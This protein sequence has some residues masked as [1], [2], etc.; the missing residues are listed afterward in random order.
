MFLV[1]IIND[2]TFFS[3][4]F[5]VSFIE[6][7]IIKLNEHLNGSYHGNHL[8]EGN[9]RN[10]WITIPL[11]SVIFTLQNLITCITEALSLYRK[12]ILI[13]LILVVNKTM[14]MIVS[15]RRRW[16]NISTYHSRHFFST[17]WVLFLYFIFQA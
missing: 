13:D 9:C 17:A 14:V 6:H 3:L 7:H 11:H 4:L 16:E 12:Y 1:A 15:R 5:S 8:L 2:Q 10:L